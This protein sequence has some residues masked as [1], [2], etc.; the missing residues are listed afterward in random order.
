MMGGIAGARLRLAV[1]VGTAPLGLRALAPV[2]GVLPGPRRA[3]WLLIPTF[4]LWAQSRRVVPDRP[5]GAG[6]GGR[7]PLARWTGNGR[8][9]RLARK[10]GVKPA[11]SARMPTP[12][13]SPGRPARRPRSSSWRCC[14]AACLV[15]PF[16]YRAY[17]AAMSPY[18]QLVPARRQNHD[19]RPALVLRAP[20]FASSSGPTGTCCRL[21]T[22]SWSLWGWARSF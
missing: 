7:R 2:P 17:A 3:L 9:R 8:A 19:R 1:N 6:R 21:S 18:L 12:Q 10:A 15:N 20:R 16:T 13:S 5:G 22:W 11:R 14:A 4:V